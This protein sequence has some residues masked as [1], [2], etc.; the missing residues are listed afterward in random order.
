[1]S[2]LGWFNDPL[3]NTVL[4]Y[5]DVSLANTVIHELLHNSIYLPG[6]AGFN[7]S[8]ANFVGDRGAIAFFCTR[9]GDDAATCRQAHDAWHDNLLYG[10]FLSDLVQRLEAIYDRTEL[11]RERILA[12]K[13]HAL[14]D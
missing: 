10:A 5:G 1:F 9:D 14:E 3:L 7:E 2:T 11:G 12:E 13:E 4:R 8:Y 6:Q